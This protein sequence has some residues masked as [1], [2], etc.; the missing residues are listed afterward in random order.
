MNAKEIERNR[1]TCRGSIAKEDD[2]QW[3][4]YLQIHNRAEALGLLAYDD[5]LHNYLNAKLAFFEEKYA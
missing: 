3:E 4:G 5:G 1:Q 2:L